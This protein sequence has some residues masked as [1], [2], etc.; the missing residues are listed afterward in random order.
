MGGVETDRCPDLLTVDDEIVAVDDR[1]RSQS[2]KVAAVV[3]LAEALAPELVHIHDRAEVSPLLIGAKRGDRRSNVVDAV[4]RDLWGRANV[5]EHPGARD[6]FPQTKAAT[7]DLD[8]PAGCSPS[9]RRN[10]ALEV[11]LCLPTLRSVPPIPV[12]R[13][14]LFFEQDPQVLVW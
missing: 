1:T 9:V 11:K 3:R 14:D 4:H 10:H 5:V 8:R 2:C 13:K 12:C 7:A 6:L